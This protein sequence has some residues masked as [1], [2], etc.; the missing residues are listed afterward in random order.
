[1]HLQHM[2]VRLRHAG[3]LDT[4]KRSTCTNI[5]EHDVYMDRKAV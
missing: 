1:M 3:L 2:Y 4:K 5:H